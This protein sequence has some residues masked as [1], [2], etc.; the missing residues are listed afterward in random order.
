ME[1]NSK[2][3]L[4]DVAKIV[5]NMCEFLEGKSYQILYLP[6][7]EKNSDEIY[8]TVLSCKNSDAEVLKT[9]VERKNYI[10]RENLEDTKECCHITTYKTS[11]KKEKISF[12]ETEDYPVKA[13]FSKNYV[14]L[15]KFFDNYIKYRK[16]LIANQQVVKREEIYLYFSS[17]MGYSEKEREYCRKRIKKLSEKDK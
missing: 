10:Y 4:I 11:E 13:S 5:K 1:E 17:I 8:T 6:T 2:L 14:Y 15:K 9:I 7:K 12:D 3:L 16:K